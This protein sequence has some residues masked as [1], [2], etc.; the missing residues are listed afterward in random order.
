MSKGSYIGGHTVWSVSDLRRQKQQ[1]KLA[2][3]V[4][5]KASSGDA[6]A[7]WLRQKGFGDPAMSR[8][9]RNRLLREAKQRWGK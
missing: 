6:R 1:E 5:P 8:S 3:Q 2:G 7:D 4:T 9:Q